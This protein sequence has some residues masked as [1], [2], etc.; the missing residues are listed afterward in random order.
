MK[1]L[2]S[3]LIIFI[4]GLFGIS[5]QLAAPQ[6]GVPTIDL[7]LDGDVVTKEEKLP[8]KNIEISLKGFYIFDEKLNKY[9]MPASYTDE[10]GNWDI[11]FS[12]AGYGYYDFYKNKS[13][14]LIIKDIDGME[15]LGYFGER[16]LIIEVEQTEE[17][18]GWHL[19]SYEKHDLTIEIDE[20][21]DIEDED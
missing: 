14:T 8:V 7:E 9:I 18:N 12:N 16:E 19:G 17:P 20:E 13:I 11:L 5:S 10:E 1:K 15:N 2:I 21:K 3:K 4:L 6:Y